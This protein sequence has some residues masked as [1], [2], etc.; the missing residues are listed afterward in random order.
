MK[1]III[2]LA[3]VVGL[4]ACGNFKNDFPDY[5]YTT[6]YFPYQYPV[7]TLVLGDDIYD[8]TNDNNHKFLISAAMGGVYENRMN[9]QLSIELAPELC[10]NV[11]FSGSGNILIMPSS[12]YTLSS[13]SSLTIPAGKIDGHIE[14]NLTDAF[15][16]DPKSIGLSYVIPVKITDSKDVDSILV[17]KAASSNPDPRISGDWDILPKDFTMFAVKFI[18]PWSGHFLHRGVTVTK[19][20]SGAVLETQVQHKPYV[21]SDEVWNVTTSGKNQVTYTG[22]LRSTTMPGILKMNLNFSDDNTCTITDAGSTFAVTGSGKFVRNGDS[23][24]DKQRNV[25]HLTYTATNGV[26]TIT[27]TDTLVVRD[28]GVVLE[29]Y[30]PELLPGK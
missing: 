10:N 11:K 22:V 26:N 18:N 23:W 24:G 14:V 28:R 21:T 13:P 2:I 9:R 16:D 7:R 30:S 5:K 15:F 4:A 8:N 6:A 1:K 25:I 19:N 27:A 3:L 20:G 29:T 17:G 12:Y